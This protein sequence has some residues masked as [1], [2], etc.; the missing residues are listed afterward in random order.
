MHNNNELTIEI[1]YI[2][3]ITNNYNNIELITIIHCTMLCSLE[4]IKCKR[5]FSN[6]KKLTCVLMGGPIQGPPLNPSV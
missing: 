4:L 2:S 3:V 5:L 1:Y 6:W